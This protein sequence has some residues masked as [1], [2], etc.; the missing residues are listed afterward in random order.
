MIKSLGAERKI[1]LRQVIFQSA[2]ND[3]SFGAD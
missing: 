1:V 3:F 2:A